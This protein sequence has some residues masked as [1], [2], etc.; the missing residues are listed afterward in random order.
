[1][2]RTRFGSAQKQSKQNNTVGMQS[3]PSGPPSRHRRLR[4]KARSE[5]Q[6]VDI[7]LADFQIAEVNSVKVLVNLVKSDVFTPED[8]TDE[9]PTFV[10][11]NVPCVVHTSSLK[12]SRIDICLCVAQ[13]QPGAWSIKASRCLVVE[14]F[15]RSFV[16]IDASE[17][18]KALLLCAKCLG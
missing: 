3:H 12:V 17:L 11:A 18:I 14:R 16:V 5:S 6:V 15:V 13:Q 10:P 9:D 7:E 2:R 1:M 8:L 4:T